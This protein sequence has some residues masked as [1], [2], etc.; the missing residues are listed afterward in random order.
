MGDS[1]ILIFQRKEVG[2]VE[3]DFAKVTQLSY[4]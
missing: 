1:I 4:G 2:C 3:N